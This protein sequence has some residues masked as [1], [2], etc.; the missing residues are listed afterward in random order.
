MPKILIDNNISVLAKIVL[1]KDFP[2]SRH[3]FELGLETSSDTE[4]WEFAKN[5]FDAILSKDKDFYFKTI[6][7]GPPP[8]LIWIT[9]GNCSNSQLLNLLRKHISE[10]K[11]FLLSDQA[12]L[13]IQ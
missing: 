8:K 6:L 13:S 9:K 7:N 1:E 5:N 12:I 11:T 4:I 10:I 2:M 3:V